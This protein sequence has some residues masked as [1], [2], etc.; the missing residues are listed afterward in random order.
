[1]RKNWYL[2]FFGLFAIFGISA[3]VTQSWVSA[4]WLVWVVWFIYFIPIEQKKTNSWKEKEGV[5]SKTFTFK[6]FN[7][8][9]DFVNK[10]GAF[11][12]EMSHHP[13]VSIYDYKYVDVSLTTHD[14][15]KVTEKDHALAK[16]IDTL[17]S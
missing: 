17:N 3:L 11:A 14:A 5:L 9:L 13:D 12:E 16:K 8:A 10:V 6:D 1:M 2:G 15:R 4:S 7:Q